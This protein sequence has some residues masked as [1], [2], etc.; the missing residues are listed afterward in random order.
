M[1]RG[2]RLERARLKG[3]TVQRTVPT[4]LRARNWKSPDS[5]RILVSLPIRPTLGH[6]VEF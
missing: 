5:V 4:A 1:V 3:E 6:D 2:V